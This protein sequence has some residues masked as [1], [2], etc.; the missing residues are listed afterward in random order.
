MLLVLRRRGVGLERL[1]CRWGEVEGVLG[2]LRRGEENF[3]WW[4]TRGWRVNGFQS[5]LYGLNFVSQF[6]IP[7]EH[8]KRVMGEEIAA[9][10]KAQEVCCAYTCLAMFAIRETNSVFYQSRH[11]ME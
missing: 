1:S 4:V 2:C 8:C 6:F 11:E 3:G 9:K 10:H 7:S 5:V